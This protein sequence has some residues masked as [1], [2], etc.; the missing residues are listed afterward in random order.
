MNKLVVLA[1][2][3]VLGTLAHHGKPKHL[4]KFPFV[5]A[6]PIQKVEQGKALE[7]K[8]AVFTFGDTALEVDE[9][10]FLKVDFENGK[11]VESNF[12]IVGKAL[13]GE[14][15]E[16][17]LDEIK[18]AV[19][20]KMKQKAGDKKGP[21]PL[22]KPHPKPNSAVFGK[23]KS[24]GISCKDQGVYVLGYGPKPEHKEG[25]DKKRPHPGPREIVVLVEGCKI[26]AP[27]VPIVLAKP[28][29]KAEQGNKL[30]AK[31]A[32]FNFGDVDLDVNE[33]RLKKFDFKSN[34]LVDTNFK[35]VGKV[36]KSE[37]LNDKLGEIKEAIKEK[38]EERAGDKPWPMPLPKPHPPPLP[39]PNSAIFGKFEGDAVGCKD[40]GLY[41]LGYG[42]IP[43]LEKGEDPKPYLRHRQFKKI[44][45]VV[46]GCNNRP[47]KF[48]V[49]L[50][51]PF[52]KAEKGEKLEVK[53][54]VFNFRDADLDLNNFHLKK[55]DSESKT[56]VDTNFKVIGKVLKGEELKNSLDE[57]KE[58]IEE[59]VKEKVEDKKGPKPLPKP[60][61]KPHPKPRPPP[62]PKPNSAIFG[63]FE[64]VVV[65]C[66]DQGV[67]VLGYGKKPEPKETKDKKRPRP[68]RGPK[69]IRKIVIA[70][71]GCKKPEPRPDPREE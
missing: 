60:H 34:E 3:L 1:T 14:E 13:K 8:F 4:P 10:H 65:G 29:H 66:K 11:L 43:E 38:I 31:F 61:P 9:V 69:P 33:V 6:K 50:A 35:V 37:E 16:D 52:H 62:L 48:P 55:F 20:E 67:Y 25:D 71:E 36:L 7:F 70:V 42:K 63:K 56:L 28:F 41:V 23:V 12:Q 19:K 27:K 17:K 40:Q 64:G 22:P 58:A 51:K 2:C 39:K 49:V 18:E 30:E 44:L 53:F 54:A 47:P 57:I 32:V 24:D 46:E 59:K 45:F 5:L 26:P 21:E 15:L 68:H